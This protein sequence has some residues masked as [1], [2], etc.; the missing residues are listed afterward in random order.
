MAR[1]GLATTFAVVALA[2]T[3][4]ACSLPQAPARVART[5]AD[6]AHGKPYPTL[7]PKD[8]SAETIDVVAKTEPVY[9]KTS[10]TAK[11]GVLNI[12]FT[13]PA[14]GNHNLNLV[15]PGAPYP[16]LWG[17]DAGSGEDHLTHAVTLQKGTYTFYCSVQGHRAAGMQ[18]TIT[19]E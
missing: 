17:E 11:A 4:S 16:L 2:A 3:A 9:E 18:G 14:S 8:P 7:A 6:A 12:S 1:S 5:N 19:V 15:G 13:S 10:F